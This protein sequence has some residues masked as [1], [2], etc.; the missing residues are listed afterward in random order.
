MLTERDLPERE[1]RRRAREEIE[2]GALPQHSIT[3]V[4]GGPG[5]G[6]PCA[7]CGELIR[8]S[9]VEYEM[10]DPGGG[11]ALRFHLACHWVWQLECA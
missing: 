5:S 7:V 11:A 2:K 9:Q 10:T 1:L 6:E 4:W 3:L 8:T